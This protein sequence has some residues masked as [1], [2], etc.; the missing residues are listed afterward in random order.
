MKISDWLVDGWQ[1]GDHEPPGQPR[2][3]GDVDGGDA[4]EAEVVVP[5]AELVPGRLEGA[6]G[7]APGRVAE[8]RIWAWKSFSTDWN[9]LLLLSLECK[10]KVFFLSYK[11]WSNNGVGATN[12]PRHLMSGCASLHKTKC[13]IWLP[14][15]VLCQHWVS[16]VGNKKIISLLK[17][18]T[19]HPGRI[20][21]Q[22]Q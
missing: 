12:Q 13:H 6:A 20:R 10:D 18:N 17:A 3:Q 14:H 1:R 16:I 19:Q 15:V 22:D 8:G 11:R 9:F 21:S 2:R 4:V 5:S 7:R